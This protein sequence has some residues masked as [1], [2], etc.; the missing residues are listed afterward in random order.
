MG[1]V[2][3]TAPLVNSSEATYITPDD[4]CA[5]A[6]EFICGDDTGAPVRHVVI[7]VKTASGKVVSVIIPNGAGEAVVYIDDGLV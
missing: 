6:V 1:N 7:E 2:S 3:I 4:S 5:A